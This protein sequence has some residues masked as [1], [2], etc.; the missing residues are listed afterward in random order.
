M[1]VSKE[2]YEALK[3]ASDRFL[4]EPSFSHPLVQDVMN[5]RWKKYWNDLTVEEEKMSDG[6]QYTL[7][8]LP[9]PSTGLATNADK[10][11]DIKM[12]PATQPVLSNVVL[13]AEKADRA[14]ERAE[15][16]LNG[17]QHGKEKKDLGRN[18]VD[19][20]ASVFIERPIYYCLGCDNDVRNNK[21]KC[22]AVH[23]VECKALQRDF[24]ETWKKVKN[25]I[26]PSAE[27]VV[28]RK[29]EDPSDGRAPI[30]GIT[31]PAESSKTAASSQT[32][33]DSEWGASSLTA[34]RQCPSYPVPDRS[35]FI[36]YNL[37]TETENAMRQLK[38]LL[39]SF[40]HLTLSFDGWS[41]RRND[42]N[43]T[44]H[45][46]TPTRMLYL[47]AGIILTGLST[48]ATS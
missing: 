19:P 22:N 47:V 26:N 13:N 28:K 9:P 4:N 37:A 39:E 11:G 24:P 30:S 46:S 33:L 29:V 44:I 18:F 48:T 32:T 42:E 45:V 34:T 15:R 43:Y 16:K 38:S 36:T 8:T 10:D 17:N 2:H 31:T 23:M 35:S 14:C 6:K 7:P 27:Q 20:M 12:A 5:A 40:I 1:G 41:S 21:R 25:A 3:T